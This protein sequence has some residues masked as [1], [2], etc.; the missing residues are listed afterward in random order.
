MLKEVIFRSGEW[1]CTLDQWLENFFLHYTLCSN[2]I[3]RFWIPSNV[4]PRYV[5]IAPGKVNFLLNPIQR[6]VWDLSHVAWVAIFVH[7]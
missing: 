5:L 2:T 7:S 6:S 4:L 1:F 3:K